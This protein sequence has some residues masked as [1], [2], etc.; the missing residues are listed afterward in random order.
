[1]NSNERQEIMERLHAEY[2]RDRHRDELLFGVTVFIFAFVV[3]CGLVIQIV[4]G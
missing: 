4:K 1:M 2:L 3:L